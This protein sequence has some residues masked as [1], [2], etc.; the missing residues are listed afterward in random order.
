MACEQKNKTPSIAL[1]NLTFGWAVLNPVI[2]D[3]SLSINGAGLYRLD[4]HNGCGKSTFIEVLSGYL[5]LIGG[6]GHINDVPLKDTRIRELVNVCRSQSALHPHLSLHDHLVIAARLNDTSVDILEK[7]G[8]ALGL[9]IRS[10]VRTSDLST[11]TVR[12]LWYIMCTVV[13][14]PVILLDEVFNGVDSQSVSVMVEEIN[15]WAKTSL[16]IFVSHSVPDG[17]DNYQNI[18]LA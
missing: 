16:V 5:P 17:L 1:K 8:I 11:G 3:F 10:S 4:G 15:M 14:K 18:L 6:Q 7:R 13:N 2:K 9:D 12:K